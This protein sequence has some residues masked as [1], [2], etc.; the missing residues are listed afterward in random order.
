MS[1]AYTR[2]LIIVVPVA[3]ASQ[4]NVRAKE[5]DTVGGERTFSVGLV[6]VGSPAGTP[7]TYYWCSWAMTNDHHTAVRSRVDTA[8]LRAAGVKV[9]DGNARSPQSVLGELGLEPANAKTGP[10]H[11]GAVHD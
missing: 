8:A 3:V 5:V 6:P 2:R 4:A 7:P 1:T 11:T 9:F 10:V